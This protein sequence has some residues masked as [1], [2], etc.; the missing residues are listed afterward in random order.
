VPP[1]RPRTP[2]VEGP[3]VIPWS[4]QGSDFRRVRWGTKDFTISVTGAAGC[5]L[6]IIPREKGSSSEAFIELDPD[7]AWT[8]DDLR[9]MAV[10]FEAAARL[11][12]A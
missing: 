10:S 6:R 9:K 11:L 8:A 5:Q 7:V 3:C 1:T 12:T 4:H 2:C